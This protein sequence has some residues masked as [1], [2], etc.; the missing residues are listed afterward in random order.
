MKP[1]ASLSGDMSSAMA[2]IPCGR[3]AAMKPPP[4]AR[5]TL[6]SRIGSPATIGE[7][8]IAPLNSLIASGRSLFLT[9]AELADAAGQVR[10]PRSLSLI[11]CPVLRS[12]LATRTSVVASGGG[13]G[14]GGGAG[15]RLPLA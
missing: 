13:G 3:T 2:R 14:A 7:R 5:T 11:A 15:V 6:E 4:L 12:V 1:P 9:K 8:T 10:Q